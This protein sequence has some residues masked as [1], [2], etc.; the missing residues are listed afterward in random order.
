MNRIT[1]KQFI[2]TFSLLQQFCPKA[3]DEMF[4]K[5]IKEDWSKEPLDTN[6]ELIVCFLRA[7]YAIKDQL[8]QY[9]PFLAKSQDYLKNNGIEPESLLKGII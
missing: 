4:L 3:I 1:L 5:M 8:S 2:S 9:E 6:K 7:N